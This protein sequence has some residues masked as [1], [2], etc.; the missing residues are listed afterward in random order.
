MRPDE[1]VGLRR[2]ARR[3]GGVALLGGEGRELNKVEQQRD[4]TDAKEPGALV[5]PP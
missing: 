1:R 3:R 2:E 4:A 5:V